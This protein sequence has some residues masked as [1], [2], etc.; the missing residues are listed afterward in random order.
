MVVVV[1]LVVAAAG[2]A[3]PVVGPVL[4]EG[5]SEGAFSA[6]TAD[7]AGTAG[8]GAAGSAGAGGTS[9]AASG[10]GSP[11][12]PPATSASTA[13]AAETPP[14]TLRGRSPKDRAHTPRRPGDASGRCGWRPSAGVG[15][16]PTLEQPGGG[17]Y[18]PV[19]TA[20]SETSVKRVTV[21]GTTPKTRVAATVSPSAERSENGTAMR[22]ASPNSAAGLSNHMRAA[23]LP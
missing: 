4:P 12:H 19:A 17:G 16:K 10:D 20:S 7:S 1:A 2:V 15:T 8:A 11:A 14:T 13:A 23:I 5:S 3:E 18:R 21:A 22:P 6:G 9:G